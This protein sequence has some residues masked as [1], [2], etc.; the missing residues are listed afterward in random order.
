MSR[1]DDADLRWICEVCQARAVVDAQPVQ[2]LW[3]GYG[4]IERC[5]LEGGPHG[6]VIVKRVRWPTGQRHPR[7]W[8]TDRSHARKVRSYAV[9]VAW[10]TDYA[11]GET[12]RV[13]HCLGAE[14][15]DDGVRLA[16]EDLDAAGFTRRDSDAEVDLRGCLSWLAHFHA[17]FLGRAPES[18]W[19]EGT[20]WHLDTRPDEWEALPSGPLKEAA[21]ALAQRLRDAP[22]QT[23][24]HGDAKLANFC[25]GAPGEVAAVDF[26]Y[27][28]GGC[29]M[30]DVAYFISSCV[31]ERD[32]E[33]VVPGMLDHYFASLR[34]AARDVDGDALE[35]SWRALYPVA[36]TDFYRFLQ[37]WSPGHPKIHR[38]SERLARRVLEDLR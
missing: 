2:T 23:F 8:A 13:P 9:E 3:S 16:L 38:Y 35:G 28:G 6:S 33:A 19:P 11:C 36:W 24:V 30:K 27:V 26:Q 15:T 34:R 18:L 7:G 29:G 12:H 1:L 37:G 31:S 25:F 10:Y 17:A 22:F 14:S 5:R 32:A 21:K 20:Y 4:S